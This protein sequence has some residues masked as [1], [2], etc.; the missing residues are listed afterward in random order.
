MS[1][2]AT[3]FILPTPRLG[4]CWILVSALLVNIINVVLKLT[5]RI[6]RY[7]K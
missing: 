2:K 4:K 5:Q 7:K 3:V 6:E 1:V